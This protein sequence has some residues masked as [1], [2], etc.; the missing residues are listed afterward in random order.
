MNSAAGS[1]NGNRR[2]QVRFTA[3]CEILHA[4]IR[5]GLAAVDPDDAPLPL[6]PEIKTGTLSN[7]LRYFIL[8]HGKP[9]KR[10]LFWLMVWIRV[11]VFV[12]AVPR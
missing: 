12:V 10:A 6:W 2:R 4:D 7:G 9:E 1:H 5:H 3:C 11:G 8:K